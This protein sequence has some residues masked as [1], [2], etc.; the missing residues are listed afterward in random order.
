MKLLIKHIEEGNLVMTKQNSDI[1]KQLCYDINTDEI[2]TFAFK[3]QLASRRGDL[4]EAIKYMKK[5]TDE[6]EVLKTSLE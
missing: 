4:P 6:F 3:I 1:I 5:I 2:K